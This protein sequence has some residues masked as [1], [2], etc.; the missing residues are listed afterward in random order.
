[1]WMFKI[2]DE[3]FYFLQIWLVSVVYE[4]YRI[5]EVYSL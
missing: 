1:M 4:D 3:Q 2:A 5:R